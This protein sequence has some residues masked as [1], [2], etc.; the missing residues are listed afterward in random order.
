MHVHIHLRT[1]HAR[2]YIPTNHPCTYIYT[3]E[4]PMHVH[5]HLRTT[6]ARTYIPIGNVTSFG[7]AR[8]ELISYKFLLYANETFYYRN[9]KIYHPQD[10]KLLDNISTVAYVIKSRRYAYAIC[11]LNI[12]QGARK[13]AEVLHMHIR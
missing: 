1:T 10:F 7:R 8:F 5:I 6:H 3:Y 9:Y 13:N 11:M 4:P 2:T 12:L